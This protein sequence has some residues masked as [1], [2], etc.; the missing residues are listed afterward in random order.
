M[1]G[2]RT[3][4]CVDNA[5]A[6]AGGTEVSELQPKFRQSNCEGENVEPFWS[7][8]RHFPGEMTPGLK[9]CICDGREVL[10]ISCTLPAFANAPVLQS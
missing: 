1:D 2:A 3:T 7:G 5:A 10:R 8:R 9:G 4:I 6:L